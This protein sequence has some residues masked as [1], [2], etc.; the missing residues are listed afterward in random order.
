MSPLL[1]NTPNASLFTLH[2]EQTLIHTW[3][4]WQLK[5]ISPMIKHYTGSFV[6]H[7]INVNFPWSFTWNLHETLLMWISSEAQLA[8]EHIW[9]TSLIGVEVEADLLVEPFF[10]FGW[11]IQ[12]H[13]FVLLL[14]QRRT[15][16]FPDS[17]SA[18]H[19]ISRGPGGL[20]F[21]LL[22]VGLRFWF[23]LI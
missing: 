3:K 7:Y 15:G 20:S 16:G 6:S 4:H 23:W 8:V 1:S 22:K 17:R 12:S 2:S 10:R 21:L 5:R 13:R 11:G 18:L 14:H 19:Q 9:K